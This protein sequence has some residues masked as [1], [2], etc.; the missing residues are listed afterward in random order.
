[1]CHLSSLLSGVSSDSRCQLT[2]G[3]PGHCRTLSLLIAQMACLCRTD[4]LHVSL[5]S[6]GFC[7]IP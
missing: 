4:L 7:D 2:C 1:M 6:A 5:T 3:T